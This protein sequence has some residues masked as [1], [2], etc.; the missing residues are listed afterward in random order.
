MKL[1]IFQQTYWLFSEI[2]VASFICSFFYIIMNVPIPF[3]FYLFLF[4]PPAYGFLF[5]I[6]RFQTKGKSLFFIVI[7]PYMLFMAYLNTISIFF[8]I[9]AVILLFWRVTAISEGEISSQLDNRLFISIFISLVLIVTGMIREY[10]FMNQVFLQIIIGIF[11]MIIGAFIGRWQL[12]KGSKKDKNQQL[13]EYLLIMF[14][15]ISGS[16][17]LSLSLKI[18]SWGYFTI[19][20]GVAAGISYVLSPLF[21]FVED[22]EI[23]DIEKEDVDEVLPDNGNFDKDIIQQMSKQEHDPMVFITIMCI[24]VGIIVL[25]YLLKKWRNQT[26]KEKEE[27]QGFYIVTTNEEKPSIFSA[28]RFKQ[29]Q[30]ANRVRKEM[31][32]LEK[33][34][35]KLNLGRMPSETIEEW[36]NRIGIEEQDAFFSTYNKVRYGKTI[37]SDKEYQAFMQ[38]IKAIKEKIKELSHS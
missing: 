32:Q 33:Y 34:A 13:K 8:F 18:W 35:K 25:F 20:K 10:A 17:L 15:F 6:H 23:Q 1:P 27:Q 36:L 37:E 16:L 9:L 4:V 26:L 7:V 30:P 24:L 14:L 22:I 38:M 28:F 3:L 29:K 2:V 5:F 12:E 11:C 31:F 21:N 19:L